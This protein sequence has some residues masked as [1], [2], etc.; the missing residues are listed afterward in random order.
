MPQGLEQHQRRPCAMLVDAA[1]K[2]MHLS[3]T[4][5]IVLVETLTA[6]LVLQNWCAEQ[7]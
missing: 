2:A 6:K 1:M 7:T 5:S 3:V 4:R